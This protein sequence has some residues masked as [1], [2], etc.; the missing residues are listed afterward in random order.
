MKRPAVCSD[1]WSAVIQ[2]D[3]LEEDKELQ[4]FNI[5]GYSKTNGRHQMI[6]DSI[7]LLYLFV[8]LMV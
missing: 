8:S 7:L 4:G 5:F 1:I 2:R 6:L 3:V